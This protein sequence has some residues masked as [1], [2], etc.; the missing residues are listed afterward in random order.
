MPLLRA[1]RGS[2]FVHHTDPEKGQSK[3]PLA[4]QQRSVRRVVR[5]LRPAEAPPGLEA[6]QPKVAKAGLSACEPILC[7]CSPGFELRAWTLGLRGS[8]SGFRFHRII[9]LKA[10]MALKPSKLRVSG[11][12]G[13]GPEFRPGVRTCRRRARTIHSGGLGHSEGTEL[14]A[15]VNTAQDSVRSTE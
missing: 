6:W 1:P 7:S 13:F 11:G 12:L 14:E 2:D 4:F 5:P 9:A 3:L 15:T 8:G 10:K